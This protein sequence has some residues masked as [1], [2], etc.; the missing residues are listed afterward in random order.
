MATCKI[1][2]YTVG[3]N[4]EFFFDT[5]VWMFIFAPLA[6][7]KQEKQRV[8]SGF[9]KDIISRGDTIW[10]NSQV[11]AEYINRCLR[12]EFDQWK[13]QTRNPLA[14]YKR[15]FRPTEDYQSA[16]KSAKSLISV[17]LQKCTRHPDDF[18]R[19]D[20]NAII[21]SMGASCDYGDAIMIELCQRKK[22]K[23]VTDDADMTKNEL[24]ITVITA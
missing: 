13:K 6:G 20:I 23:L 17:I 12:M 15:D 3:T 1:A 18:H 4:E 24:P 10:I 19:I 5:N 16:L 7:A 2:K 9:L 21:S 11:V 22:F 14:D 8:Y